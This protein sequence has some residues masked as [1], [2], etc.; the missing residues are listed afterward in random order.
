MWLGECQL[1]PRSP[2][3]VTIRS[4]HSWWSRPRGV[5]FSGSTASPCRG[6]GL[7]A[8]T[9]IHTSADRVEAGHTVGVEHLA[10]TGYLH[11]ASVV[12]LAETACGYGCLAALPARKAGFTTIELKSN[13]LATATVG[14]QLSAAATPVHLGGTTLVWD[15]TVT[16]ARPGDVARSRPIAVFRCTRMLL[17]DPRQRATAVMS[18]VAASPTHSAPLRP[19][20]TRPPSR[21]VNHRQPA[22]H[23]AQE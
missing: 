22:D 6:S 13:H 14:Q 8:I 4:A 21:L 9:L 18:G 20:R 11:A 3:T 17:D 16:T 5:R 7:L 19:N 10:A 15:A 23:P 12:A 1:A 2:H